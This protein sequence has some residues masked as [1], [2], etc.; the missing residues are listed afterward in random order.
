MVQQTPPTPKAT[1]NQVHVVQAFQ[2]SPL[3]YPLGTE[4]GNGGGEETG[5]ANWEDGGL[6][7]TLG[8]LSWHRSPRIP[9]R[10]GA[11]ASGLP[12]QHP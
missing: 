2:G 6:G 1:Y 12:V 4:E 8:R 7:F 11:P 10:A 5:M 3:L 9:T